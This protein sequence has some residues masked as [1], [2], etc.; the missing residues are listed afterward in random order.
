MTV[1]HRQEPHKAHVIFNM[2]L[3]IVSV[4]FGY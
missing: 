3:R 1:E 2:I 4:I